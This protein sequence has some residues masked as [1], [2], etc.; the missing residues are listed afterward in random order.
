VV[1]FIL[2]VCLLAPSQ[3]GGAPAKPK[4]EVPQP[5]DPVRELEF[6][7]LL[8]ADQYAQS[9]AEW[10]SQL[11]LY[12]AFPEQRRELLEKHPVKPYWE[13]FEALAG[14][15]QPQAMLWL[16]EHA[17]KMFADQ[18]E[19]AKRKYAQLRKL[20]DEHASS[21]CGMEIVNSISLQRHWIEI[22]GVEDLLSD[23]AKKTKNREYAAGALASLVTTLT[24]TSM[25]DEGRQRMNQ[26]T[27]RILR[28]YADT[29][30]GRQFTD[31]LAIQ[32]A[33]RLTGQ[34]AEG[35][36]G[37]DVDGAELNLRALRGK[38]V[39]LEFW[40]FWNPRSR[41]LI[42]QLRELLG[43]HAADPLVVLGVASD[44]DPARFRELSKQ[45]NV[46]WPSVW[47]GGR[48]GPVA[49]SYNVR[50]F[51]TLYLI[52][53]Q[54]VIQRSWVGTQVEKSFPVDIDPALVALKARSK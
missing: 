47:D 46:S 25:T 42:P 3:D 53:S 8:L 4:P 9:E 22:E 1:Q 45:N 18:K 2:A 11:K 26:A 13:R 14:L 50:V 7:Y 40:G 38:V 41:S 5:A 37:K 12:A 35:F 30:A 31:Q 51:P 10:T 20:V 39:L 43:R 27:E 28:E 24:A 15:G 44:E 23:F 21:S 54:G 52:D 32:E 29:E 33:A 17:D 36:V 34:F 16:V 19:V 6:R 48:S 49:R